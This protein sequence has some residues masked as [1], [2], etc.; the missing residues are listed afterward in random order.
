M[1][2]S[3]TTIAGAY[4]N[5]DEFHLR[6]LQFYRALSQLELTTLVLTESVSPNIETYGPEM[7]L[8]QGSFLLRTLRDRELVSSILEIQK[9]RGV[10]VHKRIL[11]YRI[12]PEGF[13]VRVQEPVMKVAQP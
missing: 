12:T 8:A 13:E 3:L 1:I 4:R 2:D 9:M 5:A 11:S 6:L 10:R 7:I